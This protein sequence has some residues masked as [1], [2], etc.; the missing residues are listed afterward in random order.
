VCVAE[1]AQVAV[2]SVHLISEYDADRKTGLPIEQID[3]VQ[4]GLDGCDFVALF[5]ELSG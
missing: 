2:D 5:A 3:G 1:A 4:T